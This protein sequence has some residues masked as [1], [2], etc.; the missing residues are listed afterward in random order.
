MSEGL[1][2]RPT[3]IGL[4]DLSDLTLAEKR[5]RLH[6]LLRR[7]GNGAAASPLSHGQLSLWFVYQLA[8][9]S[10]AY[11]FAYAAEVRSPLDLDALRRAVRTLAGRHPALRTTFEFSSG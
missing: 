9:A 8:P 4:D 2:E 1:L 11:N 7:K 5:R 10:P 3:M 6:E